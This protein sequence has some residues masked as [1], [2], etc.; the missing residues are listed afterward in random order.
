MK[1]A[2]PY[3][4]KLKEFSRSHSNMNRLCMEL[5]KWDKTIRFGKSFQNFDYRIM[6]DPDITIPAGL[7]TAVEPI[8]LDFCREMQELGKEQSMI[9]LL[10]TSHFLKTVHSSAGP[11][12]PASRH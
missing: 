12:V 11:H 8:Y 2:G 7:F 3:Y 5:E 10:Y 1:Y 9:C 6:L 4:A